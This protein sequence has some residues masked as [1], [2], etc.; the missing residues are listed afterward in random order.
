MQIDP[1][2]Q[3][4]PMVNIEL[5]PYLE[6]KECEQELLLA[7]GSV[8][9]ITRI[10]Q[11]RDIYRVQLTLSG[12]ID[13]QLAEYTRRTREQTRTAHSFLSLLRLMS[14]LSQYSYVDQFAKMLRED[15]ALG[16]NPSLLG[17]IH[18]IFGTIYHARGQPKMAL[19]HYQKTLNINLNYLSADDSAITATYNNIGCVYLSQ[20]NYDKALEYQKLALDCQTK[21]GNPNPSSMITYTNNLAKIYTH[22][23]KYK[24]ALDYHKRALELQKQFLGENDPSTYRD[25]R[26]D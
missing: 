23:G 1:S 8:F 20:S 24:E 13:E 17:A 18:H 9:R 2:I 14:E 16:T 19:D 26:S 11:Q 12:D 15:V 21:S 7:M 5:I 22:Q 6:K 4:F 3:K 25:L 10:E